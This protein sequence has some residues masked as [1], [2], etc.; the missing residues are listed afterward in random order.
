[1]KIFYITPRVPYPIDKGDKLRAFYQIKY[2][3]EKHE[4]FL[5]ALDENSI[6]NPENNPLVKFCSHVKITRLSLVKIFF[7]LLRGFFSRVPFQTS[8]Y[9]SSKIAKDIKKS[10]DEYKPDLIYCQ[11]I[12]T[13]KLVDNISDIPKI[14][15]YVDVISKG[16]E[17]RL[18]QSDF[19]INCLLKWEMHRT[20]KYEED[21]FKK[22]DQKIII[23]YED[24]DLLPIK[25]KDKVHVVPNGIDLEYFYPI[26]AEKKFD[27][28]FSGNL[29]Y[30]PNINASEFLVKK[31]MPEVWKKKVDV[32]LTIAGANPKKRIL[33][34]KSERVNILGWTDDIRDY[35]KYARIF[36]A[37]LQIGTGLQNKLLQAMA[38]R[39]PC[40]VSELTAKGLGEKNCEYMLV[41]N[42]PDEYA[43]HIIALLSDKQFANQ[44]ADNG[45]KYVTEN[46]SW[47]N[48]IMNLEKIVLDSINRKV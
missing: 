36:I 20:I 25:E 33:D 15:D 34:L 4:I 12:R 22:F 40:I 23:T 30:P 10:I 48:I 37:P 21:V 31:I 7:N 46:Y 6:Y 27:L 26:E 38:M 44:L 1:M 16:L 45:F 47:Q 18:E 29:S 32:N 42:S 43:K 24:R 8:F 41:A 39:L 11:L 14:I 3:S 5:Y 28:F 9:F 2:L 13:A 19:P 35:Y 17:R